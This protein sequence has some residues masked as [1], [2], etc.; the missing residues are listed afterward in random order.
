MFDD[1]IGAAEHLIETGVTTAKQLAIRGG[2]NGGLLVCATSTQRPDLFAAAHAA[3]PVT[4]MLRF[5]RFTIGY[6]WCSDYGNADDNEEEFLAMRAYS[7]LHTVKPVVDSETGANVPFPATLITTSDHDDRVVPLHSFKMIAA[8]QH[9]ATVVVE[10]EGG[11]V[12]EAPWQRG[13][14]LLCRIERKAGHGAGKPTAKIIEEYADVYAF[15]AKYTGATF[16][17]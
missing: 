5:H 13:R 2:S 4:D 17:N 16:S 3:V 1:F 10:G 7:P 9:A 6:A 15:L 12:V 11:K 14:P 8:L